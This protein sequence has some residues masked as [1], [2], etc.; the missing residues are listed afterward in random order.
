M[1]AIDKLKPA[2]WNPRILKDE[3]F[4][5]LC[6]SLEN[7]P[8]FMELRPILATKDGTIYGGNMRYRAAKHL[9]WKEV[10]AVMSDIP[11]TL[12]KE[13]AI[14]DNNQFGEWDDTLSTLLDELEKEGVDLETLGLEE[15]IITAL[16]SLDEVEED[17][18]P[19]LPAK[20]KSKLGE[21]Y[22]LG[23]HRLLCGDATKVED[24]ERLMDG[25][26]ADMVLTDPPYNTGMKEKP[27]STRLSHMFNDSFTDEEF[28]E[29]LDGA[30]ANYYAFTKG[31]AAFYVC[32]D[33]RQVHTIREAVSKVAKVSNV[34]VWDKMVHGLGSDYKYTYELIVVGKKGKPEIQNRF[35]QDYQDVWHVQ[36]KVGRNEDHATAKPIELCSKP[37]KH[38]SK[39]DDIV[40]DFFGG[41]GSTLIAAEQL[42]RKCYM[43]ELSPAYID[44]IITRWENLTQKKAKLLK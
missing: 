16:D 4:K 29:L 24:V 27:D 10:P 38:A 13:R 41:S 5:Q 22:Q 36:R 6:K 40:L 32:I 19:P 8:E 12:A 14:K 42:K 2:E 20:P 1:I 18:A 39:Q 3:R 9:G 35:G 43:I 23:N 17:E 15:S 11:E 34:I 28:V 26:K 44:T 25:E 30:M 21:L 7:D 31:E 33:W 37:I